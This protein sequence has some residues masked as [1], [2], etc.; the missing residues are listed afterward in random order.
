MRKKYLQ[1]GRYHVNLF[2]LQIYSKKKK[3]TH[4]PK[5]TLYFQESLNYKEEGTNEVIK[6]YRVALW[7]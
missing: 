4:I 6:K 2:L 3:K 1:V 5:M 7:Q